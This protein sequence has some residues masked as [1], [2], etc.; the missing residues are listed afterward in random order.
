[1]LF[2]TLGRSSLPVV[3]AQPDERHTTEQLLCWSGIT[4]TEHYNTTSSSNEEEDLKV[5]ILKGFHTLRNFSFKLAGGSIEHASPKFN[6]K[7]RYFRHQNSL[8]KKCFKF[9][10]YLT[11]P[12]LWKIRIHTPKC[13]LV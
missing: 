3:V 4:D 1:M 6:H 8:N 5:Q 7:Y 2:P 12:N 9:L 10:V 13:K 11:K